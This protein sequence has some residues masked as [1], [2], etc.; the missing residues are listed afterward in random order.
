MQAICDSI[1]IANSS[2]S[3]VLDNLEERQLIS[4]EKFEKDK[5]VIKVTLTSEGSELIKNVM[6][7]HYKK[8]FTTI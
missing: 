5:R 1:L 8:S 3:Y 2:M 6:K 7:R 4:R